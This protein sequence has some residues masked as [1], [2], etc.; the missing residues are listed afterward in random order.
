MLSVIT[1]LLIEI[2]LLNPSIVACEEQKILSVSKVTTLGRWVPN[3]S[4]QL[5]VTTAW[6]WGVGLKFSGSS[7]VTFNFNGH[8]PDLKNNWYGVVIDGNYIANNKSDV[9]GSRWL[10]ST[11]VGTHSVSISD[12]NKN[13]T[14]IFVRCTDEWDYRGVPGNFEFNSI[15]LDGGAQIYDTIDDFQKPA[16]VLEAWGDSITC[17]HC[18]LSYVYAGCKVSGQFSDQYM[19]YPRFLADMMGTKNWRTVCVSGIGWTNTE[20]FVGLQD[21]YQCNN[22]GD[23]GAPCFNDASTADKFPSLPPADII[24]M[25][26]GTNDFKNGSPQGGVAAFKTGYKKAIDEALKKNPKAYIFLL[27]PPICAYATGP[28]WQML[29]KTV[30]DI[31]RNYNNPQVMVIAPYSGGKPWWT[32]EQY[33]KQYFPTDF[34]HPCVAGHKSMAD[35]YCPVMKQL[36][37]SKD[38]DLAAKLNCDQKKIP[39]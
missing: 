12:P 37:E 6:G 26:M 2:F 19:T 17:G 13:H 1:F 20:G 18:S 25:N 4:G 34:T 22:M 39:M 24:T 3:N 23:W 27:T 28:G 11:S 36:L 21:F 14:V 16:L 10:S 30:P 38:P 15:E 32:I 9:S 29:N 7:K 8:T 33:E 31:A 5:P 35:H